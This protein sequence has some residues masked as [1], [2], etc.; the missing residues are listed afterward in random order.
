MHIR[1][2]TDQSLLWDQSSNS[3]HTT[4]QDDDVLSINSNSSN[5]TNGS[6]Q[7]PPLINP[8]TPTPQPTIITRLMTT[9]QSWIIPTVP[10]ILP[11]DPIQWITLNP[12][13]QILIPPSEPNHHPINHQTLIESNTTNQ[14]WGD[15]MHCPKP[16]NMFQVLS[17][18]I[19]TMSNKTDYL[20][21]KAAAHAIATSKADA[22]AFQETNQA[23]TKIHQR[24]VQQ[25]LQQPKGNAVIATSSST[26]ISIS[27]H[28][29]G[30]TLIGDWTSHSMQTGQDTSSLG[31]WS[32]IK[33]QGKEDHRYIILSGYH[34][35]ENQ[36]IDP[37]SN[38]MFNQQY[39]L[40]HQQGHRNPNPHAQFVED[41]ITIIKQWQAQNKAVLICLDANKNPQHQGNTGWDRTNL[42][43]DWPPWS[44]QH[45][46][47]RPGPS[48]YLQ[49]WITT[50]QCMCWQPWVCCS[51]R[52]C[53]VP[54]IWQTSGTT[55]G[56]PNPRVRFQH[57]T[58]VLPDVNH[59]EALSKIQYQQQQH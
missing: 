45:L 59:C 29:Q 38:N 17:R 10:Q 1:T 40:L 33:L 35:C 6:I 58:I 48:P 4:H 15:P 54:P 18:N 13:N 27:P 36:K 56:P 16:F 11:L 47:S 39:H 37:G 8:Y 50:H 52:N 46:T 7:P 28:Q 21:W 55:W 25:I 20:L 53:M 9:L 34:I 24:R 12:P 44:P 51:P 49:P 5:S 2:V 31:H 23:W 14:H 22:G 30:G 3:S 26:E 42:L 32:Y 43:Q 19:N 57:Q 41:L